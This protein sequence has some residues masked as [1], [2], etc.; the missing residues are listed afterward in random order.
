MPRVCTGDGIAED[1]D[2]EED[3]AGTVVSA[4][5]QS[6]ILSLPACHD[7]IVMGLLQLACDP[8]LFA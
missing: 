6:G 4:L 2:S 7:R 5:V 3:L 1:A 8:E